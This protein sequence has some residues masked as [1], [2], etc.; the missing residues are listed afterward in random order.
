M[1]SSGEELDSVILLWQDVRDVVPRMSV[2]TLFQP[3]LIHVVTWREISC[4]WGRKRGDGINEK[5]MSHCLPMKPMLLPKT[6]KLFIEPMSMYSCASSLKLKKKKILITFVRKKYIVA[7][8]DILLELIYIR[9][10]CRTLITI[11]FCHPDE[12]STKNTLGKKFFQLW[13]FLNNSPFWKITPFRFWNPVPQS[14]FFSLFVS[15]LF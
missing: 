13:P 10:E 12:S 4:Y 15:F 8:S 5:E 3:L 11:K 14:H 1:C 2:Q 7:P 6:N 9:L